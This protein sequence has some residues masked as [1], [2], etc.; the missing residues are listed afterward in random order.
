MPEQNA[1]PPPDE[2]AGL[3]EIVGEFSREALASPDTPGETLSLAARAR[4]AER[5]VRGFLGDTP[6]A[7]DAPTTKVVRP[8]RWWPVAPA[9]AAA[10][11]LALVFLRSPS[12]LGDAEDAVSS[13]VRGQHDAPSQLTAGQSFFLDCHVPG[14]ELTVVGLRAARSTDN[15]PR[16]LGFTVDT[17]A[18]DGAKLHAVADLPR[19]DWFLTCGVQTDDGRFHWLAPAT[20]LTVE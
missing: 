2:L 7:R 6:A 9:L 17:A 15:S 20:S 10:A 8:R 16:H 1:S 12:P 14:A 4:I 11:T 13:A 5:V 3:D 18:A 19:G